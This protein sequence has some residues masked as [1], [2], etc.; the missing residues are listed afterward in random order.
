[1]ILLISPLP[2]PPGGDSTWTVRYLEYCRNEGIPISHV[3][4]AVIGMRATGIEKA[5]NALSEL[6]RAFRIWC[7]VRAK[8]LEGKTDVV[9]FNTN[10]SPKGL[11]RD[12]VT[13]RLIKSI[14]VPVAVHCRC[15]VY[16]QIGDSRIGLR[17]FKILTK[18]AT[19]FIALNDNS[20]SF[21]Q[22]LGGKAVKIPNFICDDEIVEKKQINDSIDK[23]IFVG[24]VIPT[25]GIIELIAAEN[26]LPSMHFHIVGPIHSGFAAIVLPSNVKLHGG[27]NHKRVK[28]LL[29]ESDVF[30]FP[31]Y[32]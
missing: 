19:V 16:D 2:P 12:V 4:T 20:L 5:G 10:C 23:V 30:V 18:M 8:L 11:M 7:R 3:N 15:N 29:D 26:S 24:H 14:G 1:M 28:E 31:T 32:L 17:T 25:K 22:K 6:L 27:V 21:I 9:H 13:L